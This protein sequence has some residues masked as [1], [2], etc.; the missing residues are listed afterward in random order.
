MSDLWLVYGPPGTGKTRFLSRQ[1]ER[2]AAAHGPSQVVITSMTRTAAHEIASRT[3]DIPEDQ[4]GT[5]H[6]HAYRALDRPDL[7]ETPEAIREWNAEHPALELTTGA[8]LDD[9]LDETSGKTGGDVLHATCMNNRA[10]RI[11]GDQWGPEERDYW[12]L[13]SD[14][15]RHTGRLDFTDLIERAL[16][17]V[18][19]HP[20]APE[21]FLLDEAQDFS[22]LELALATSW[23]R[24]TDSTVIVGDPD[25]TLYTWRGS[26]HDALE[27]LPVTGT[28]VLEQSY[29]VPA[30][31]H[32]LAVN[33][34]R[35]IPG[36]RDVTYHPTDQPARRGGC[37][38][39]CASPASCSTR[40][41][42]TSPR[43]A[44]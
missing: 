16:Y 24:H 26:D 21:V 42:R 6:A 33:W 10:R 14:F 40:S 36:R 27:Q 13:W 8:S 41:T 31:V 15:K 22:R 4:V 3:P 25:Q 30:A 34:V 32:D 37:R 38:S 44:P 19:R 11:P 12:Q 7:A 5:L 35:Q 2:A 28:R 23:A 1:A 9:G 20:S 18:D 39:A 43:A 17:D 29:R